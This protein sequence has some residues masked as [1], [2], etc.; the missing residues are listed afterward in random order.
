MTVAG[1]IAVRVEFGAGNLETV[2]T[3]V[4]SLRS[5]W[6]GAR[7][8]CFLGRRDERLAQVWLLA[9]P[10]D[11]SQDGADRLGHLASE[12][13]RDRDGLRVDGCEATLLGEEAT[14]GGETNESPWLMAIPYETSP[15]EAAELDRWYEEEHTE[16]L[17]RC[18]DW[19]RVRRFQV[20]STYGAAWN[21]LVL[22]D[23]STEE[24]I[25]TAEVA[26]S[27][28]TPWRLALA[29][30]PWFLAGGRRPLRRL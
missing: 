19:V 25:S 21:R 11:A 14:I 17:L 15:E 2:E 26:A 6:T 1:L 10:S 23:L 20:T 24:V 9:E 18:P 30:R 27:M 13:F 29:Q 5:N 28:Q 12:A 22:H 3:A 7:L 16:M 8:D 4:A